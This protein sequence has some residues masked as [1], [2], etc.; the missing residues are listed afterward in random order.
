M[1]NIFSYET[2][3]GRINIVENNNAIIEIYFGENEIS[4]DIEIKETSLIKKTIKQLEEYFM[5]KRK[6]FDISIFSEGTEFQ[7]KVWNEL[8]NIPYGETRSYGEIAKRVNNPKG[9]RAIG[10]ANNKNPI[11]I[12][13]PCHRVIGASGKLVGYGGGLDIKEKLLK[14][15]KEN[16]DS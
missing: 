9:A 14:L 15:E 11:S 4:N 5:G 10:M 12:I 7:K 2:D 8:I 1:K 6:A 3:I 16:L 13:I